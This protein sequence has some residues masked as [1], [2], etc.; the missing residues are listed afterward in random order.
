MFESLANLWGKKSFGDETDGYADIRASQ[1]QMKPT[2]SSDRWI[3]MEEEIT[4]LTEENGRLLQERKY[5]IGDLEEC[6]AELFKRMP[7]TQISDSSIQTVFEQIHR[8]ID[9]LVYDVM[10]DV[11]DD[12]ALYCYCLNLQRRPKQKRRRSRDPL[13]EFFR[14]ANISTW[15]P[16]IC[17]NLYILSVVIQCILENFVFKKPCPIGITDTQCLVLKEV[18]KAMLHTGQAPGQAGAHVNLDWQ[19][20]RDGAGQERIDLWRSETLT[21]L[22]ALRENGTHLEEVSRRIRYAVTWAIPFRLG[23]LE[24]V[25]SPK[26]KKGF[27]KRS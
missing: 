12:D 24:P 18:E 25:L 26:L 4:T 23:C 15:G 2:E 14:K 1:R 5:L 21:A 17:S 19:S 9:S 10:D 11:V 20:N 16:Y 6:K 3:E 7:P 8:S 13:H 22:T 27:G